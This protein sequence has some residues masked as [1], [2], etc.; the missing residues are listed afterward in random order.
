MERVPLTPDQ[1]Q[2]LAEQIHKSALHLGRVNE[3]YFRCAVK[4]TAMPYGS[5]VGAKQDA[6][7]AFL[8]LIASAGRMTSMHLEQLGTLLEILEAVK[9]QQPEPVE[10]TQIIP[11]PGRGF[12]K[13]SF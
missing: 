5:K 13:G 2:E 7:D 8:E 11:P 4:A 9:D 12:F 1:R 6:S 3:A 10:P